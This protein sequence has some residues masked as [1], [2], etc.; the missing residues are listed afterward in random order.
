MYELPV[1][2]SPVACC[3]TQRN[4]AVLGILDTTTERADGELFLLYISMGQMWV[5]RGTIV[6][7][8][9]NICGAWYVPTDI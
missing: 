7:D 4:I 8:V 6:S 3:C 9:D 5:A 1:H 2:V